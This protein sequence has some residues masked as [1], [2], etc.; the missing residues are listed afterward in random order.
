[1]RLAAVVEIKETRRVE[2]EDH[3]LVAMD[4]IQGEQQL[5]VLLKL[6]QAAVVEM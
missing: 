4:I 3:Q 2:L 1:M 5:Q 6:D